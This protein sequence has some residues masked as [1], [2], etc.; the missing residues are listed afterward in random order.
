MAHFFINHLNNA[1]KWTYE[2]MDSEYNLDI[3]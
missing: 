2:D 3:F 1:Q